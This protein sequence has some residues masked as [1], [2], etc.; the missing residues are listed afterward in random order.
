MALATLIQPIEPP[1]ERKRPRHREAIGRPCSWRLSL[2]RMPASCRERN[3]KTRSGKSF[4]K[5]HGVDK[6]PRHNMSFSVSTPST[7][8]SPFSMIAAVR[9]VD[10]KRL[11]AESRVSSGEQN[12]VGRLAEMLPT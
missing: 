3:R 11:L 5:R 10:C 2:P 9:P 8:F 12:A 7:V 4:G 6:S 1:E